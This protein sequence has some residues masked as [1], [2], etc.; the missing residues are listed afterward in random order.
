MVSAY[1]RWAAMMP[2]DIEL[3]VIYLPGRGQ[4]LSETPFARLSQLLPVL[5]AELQPYCDIP[6]AFLGH[7]MG[8][9]LAFEA[10]RY[11]RHHRLKEPSHLFCCSCPS[12]QTPTV[13][14]LIHTLPE[15]AFVAEINRRYAAIPEA[16]QKDREM[17]SLFL[18]GLRA[19]FAML[20]TYSY[21]PE[22]P[23]DAAISVY[24]GCND[25]VVSQSALE[26]WRQ[27]TSRQFELAMF[28]GDHF[29]VH[30]HTEDLIAK[31]AE[32]LA[33]TAF[34]AAG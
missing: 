9:I 5:M 24:G 3:C 29:F 2:V 6:V 7:S 8:A 28:E 26:G 12:P 25:R 22:P 30:S 10:A 34:M 23:L 16:I 15:A 1:A 4:R 21:K 33:S 13:A 11:L 32:A 17:L 14:P 27:H 20:E 18:P 31:V 19:D